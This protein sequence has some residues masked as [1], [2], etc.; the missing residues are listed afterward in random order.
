MKELSI[1]EKAKAYD[2]LIERLKDLQFAYR[3]SPLSDTIE[4]NFPELKENGDD[5]IRKALIDGFTVM[6]ESKNCSKTFSKHNIPVADIL[7]WL[8]KLV[9][10][11]KFIPGDI[12]KHKD[13]NETFEVSKIEIFDTDEIYYHL[14]N[15]GCVGENS[16]NFERV[17]QKSVIKVYPKFKAGDWIVYNDNLYHITNMALHGY[18]ECIRVDGTIHTFSLDIDSKSHLWTIQDAKD[19]DVLVDDIGSI[20]IF[21]GIGNQSWDDV[22]DFYVALSSPKRKI[23]IQNDDEYWAKKEELFTPANKEHCDLLFQKM[24]E[25]GYEWD[26]K[27]KELKEIEQ[28]NIEG[29]F[30]NVDEVREN[31]IKEVYR[32][33]GNDAT[34]DRANDI[35]YYFDSLPTICLS[36]NK[37]LPSDDDFDMNDILKNQD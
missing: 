36:T 5:R 14:T 2:G 19:G 21:R 30:I 1:K 20:L 22:V 7:Y 18:Y 10:V 13:T 29:T 11:P 32:V 6:K 28:K 8:E 23:I 37:P 35:I 12:I 9:I 27:K 15:G 24:K 4:E 16:D 31:F 34:N 25:A 33:L 3:F 26:A 17:E